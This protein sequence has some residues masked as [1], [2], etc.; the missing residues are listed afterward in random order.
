MAGAAPTAAEA[1]AADLVVSAG[2][3]V[4]DSVAAAPAEVGKIRI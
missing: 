2:E 3:L 1:L 4:V